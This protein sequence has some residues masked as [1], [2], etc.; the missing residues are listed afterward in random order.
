MESIPPAHDSS[1]AAAMLQTL[2]ALILLNFKS[3]NKNLSIV[4]VLKEGA[5]TYA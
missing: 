2:H 3:N 1:T 4:P 5:L